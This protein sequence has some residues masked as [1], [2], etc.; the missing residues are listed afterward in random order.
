MHDLQFCEKGGSKFNDG[1]NLFGAWLRDEKERK[2]VWGKI[3]S[4][5]K[6]YPS[7]KHTGKQKGKQPSMTEHETIRVENEMV[8]NLSVSKKILDN[9]I[10][11][12]LEESKALIKGSLEVNLSPLNMKVDRG[13]ENVSTIS[14][15]KVTTVAE[16]CEVERTKEDDI[17]LSGLELHPNPHV[18]V[19][20]PISLET[21]I[22]YQ[23]STPRA[24]VE[25]IIS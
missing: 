19:S 9:D 22:L 7:L 10:T 21:Q 20:W 4:V 14:C 18:S 8:A 6:A 13:I 25:K 5:E 11:D 12:H 2:T 1:N 24:L 3:D 23:T 17:R 16:V 15:M